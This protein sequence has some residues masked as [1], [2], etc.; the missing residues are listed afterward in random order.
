MKI[1]KCTLIDYYFISIIIIYLIISLLANTKYQI[2]TVIIAILLSLF[3]FNLKLKITHIMWSILFVLFLVLFITPVIHNSRTL[4]FRMETFSEKINLLTD[5]IFSRFD[6]NNI[7][8]SSRKYLP[9]YGTLV[10]RLD[11]LYE[12][13]KVIAGINDVGFVGSYPV[14]DGFEKALPGFMAPNRSQSATTDKIMWDIREK[15]YLIISRVTIGLASSVYAVS[16]LSSLFLFFPL[17]F[18]LFIFVLTKLF[19]DKI[20]NNILGIFIL[21]KYLLFFTEKTFSGLMVTLLRDLPLTIGMVFI[22]M[23][24]LKQNKKGKYT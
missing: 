9:L 5:A 13:D 2:I 20:E 1:F 24:F 4:E 6:N 10:D 12:T 18:F 16:G 23:F 11:I 7:E 19:G 17:I 8:S 3:S 22:V 21:T 15:N 14:T